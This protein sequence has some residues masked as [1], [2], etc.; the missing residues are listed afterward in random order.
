MKYVKKIKY[1][2]LAEQLKAVRECGFLIRYIH[3]PSEEVMK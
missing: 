3:N 2:S 1:K